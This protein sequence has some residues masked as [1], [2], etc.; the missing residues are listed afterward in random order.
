MTIL[1]PTLGLDLSLLD[2]LEASI[3]FDVSDVVVIGNGKRIPHDRTKRYRVLQQPKNQGVAS[4]WN[5]CPYIWP[6][7]SHYLVLNDDVVLPPGMVKEVARY[8]QVESHRHPIVYLGEETGYCAFLW[9]RHAV[10]RIGNFDENFWP[11]YYEDA[12][13]R[14]RLQRL[15]ISPPSIFPGWAGIQHGKPTGIAYQNMI[16]RCEE[17]LKEYFTSKWGT[18]TGAVKF[19]HPF[20]DSKNQLHEWS[21]RAHM[22]GELEVIFKQWWDND[23]SLYV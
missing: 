21:L 22:R 12:D 9:T 6:H 19:V 4:S 17:H 2:R 7:A 15:G 23:P 10:E 8:A 11:A 5:L 16:K 18:V 13:M 3:D 14:L 20:G 1:V